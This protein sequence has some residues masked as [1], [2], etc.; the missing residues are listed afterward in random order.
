MCCM[1]TQNNEKSKVKI[2]TSSSKNETTI[3]PKLKGMTES[4]NHQRKLI[5]YPTTSNIIRITQRHYTSNLG[6]LIF[7]F[8]CL[9]VKYI[10]NFDLFK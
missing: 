8:S 1:S 5:T 7:S 6:S 9:T 4:S 3:H 2:I 10:Y